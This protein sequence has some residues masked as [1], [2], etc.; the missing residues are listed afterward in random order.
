MDV[1]IK[2]D[3]K[4]KINKIINGSIFDSNISFVTELIQNA[5]RAKS[6]YIDFLIKDN[7]IIVT[8]NGVGLIDIDD[9]LTLDYSSWESTDEGFGIGFWSILAIPGLNDVRIRSR[10]NLLHIP[11]D[12][13]KDDLN[14]KYEKTDD[15]FDGF[16]LILEGKFDEK[17][18]STVEE[19]IEAVGKFVDIEVMLNKKTIEKES[20]YNI[21][22]SSY[23]SN[24]LDNKLFSGRIAPKMY[25]GDISVYYNNRLVTKLYDFMG[26]E[27]IIILKEGAVD[28]KEP[29]RKFFI[30]NEKYSKFIDTLRKCIKK[31]YKSFIKEKSMDIPTLFIDFQAG[32]S[33]YCSIVDYE[34][35]LMIDSLIE[36]N[37]SERTEKLKEILYTPNISKENIL[38]I[39]NKCTEEYN[40]Y[41]VNSNNEAPIDVD[42]NIDIKDIIN[43]DCYLDFNEIE[44][45]YINGS[46]YTKHIV[47]TSSSNY[48]DKCLEENPLNKKSKNNKMSIKQFVKKFKNIFW[49]ESYDKQEYENE[50]SL[51]E[52]YGMKPIIVIHNLYKEYFIQKGIPGV[53]DLI[54]NMNKTTKIINHQ[55]NNKKEEKFLRM[56]EP[57]LKK[58]SLPQNVFSIG[59]II[60]TVKLEYKGKKLLNKVIK[61]KPNKPLEIFGVREYTNIILDRRALNLKKFNLNTKSDDLGINE[62]KALM[63]SINTIAH[64]LSHLMYN[65]VDNTSNHIKMEKK[66]EAELIE[67]YTIEL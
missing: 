2:T 30:K 23:Y 8:D 59:D 1:K 37:F 26:V 49:V 62:L 5:Q 9:L 11:L 19:E 67:L 39:L 22:N 16:M 14:V 56:L 47:E 6:E 53:Y 63:Y 51:L 31:L 52:Y 18:I 64:E 48:N 17:Y 41:W 12:T 40:C 54:N 35:Y 24:D 15:T 55:C 66:I 34:D 36:C 58:Y 44:S 3:T 25:D 13:V 42:S 29:D 4:N 60:C 45:V 32:I 28:L 61:N 38:N 57:I 33:E 7:K 46:L 43:E 27:G 20:L 10:N 50:I 65:T 21:C